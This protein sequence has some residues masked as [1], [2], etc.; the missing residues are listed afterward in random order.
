MGRT[1]QFDVGIAA[2]SAACCGR[3]VRL[4][5]RSTRK[6]TIEP[7]YSAWEADVLPRHKRL[8]CRPLFDRGRD[9][10][11]YGAPGTMPSR[12]LVALLVKLPALTSAAVANLISEPAAVGRGP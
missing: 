9:G 10:S 1:A 7:A 11:P 12:I 5:T 4:L 6:P 3:A 8:G 2:L